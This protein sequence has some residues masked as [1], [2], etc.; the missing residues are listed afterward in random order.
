MTTSPASRRTDRLTNTSLQQSP[1]LVR[2]L[3]DERRSG[4]ERLSLASHVALPPV[5]TVLFD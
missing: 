2:Q 3:A 5:L 4:D 1:A